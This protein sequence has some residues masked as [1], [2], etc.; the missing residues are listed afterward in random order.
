M[1]LAS[2]LSACLMSQGSG[3]HQLMLAVDTCVIRR[4]MPSLPMCSYWM[5]PEV[6]QE[7][8]YDARADIWSLGITAIEL[9]DGEP[10]YA[11][12]HPMRA[13][14]MIPSREPP[15]LK[16]PAEWS[17][18]F[19]DFIA[20]CLKKDFTQRPSAKALLKHPF[21]AAAVARLD[22]NRGHSALIGEL[23]ERCMPII[24]QARHE[25]NEADTGEPDAGAAPGAAGGGGGDGEGDGAGWERRGGA[26]GGSATIR[27]ARRGTGGAGTIVAGTM[28]KDGKLL[29]RKSKGTLLAATA[30][31]GAAAGGGGAGADA[32]TVRFD[33][34][35]VRVASDGDEGNGGGGGGG[36]ATGTLVYQSGTM[37]MESSG[38][39]DETA[40]GAVP[41]FMAYYQNK[42][43]QQ[44]GRPAAA[45]VAA[46]AA[47]GATGTMRPAASAGGGTRGAA[48]TPAVAAPAKE[49][50]IYD[51]VRGGTF[52][53]LCSA[54]WTLPCRCVN[55][56][57][58]Q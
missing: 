49:P 47:G 31:R 25:D 9:A 14:F 17:A 33:S 53:I 29:H 41:A 26:G 48:A 56:H 52:A 32:G 12:I 19:N 54:S 2:L 13:I 30:R 23:V 57:G 36:G 27:T 50:D 16:R 37:A 6:I 46:A 18:A 1:L 35:T 40:D 39:D 24:E 5:S 10:P 51:S 55:V 7:S 38:E 21:V 15:K 11:D 3:V 20:C 28:V 22:A 4:L 8:A 43:Q 42:Q 45:A 34:G 44:P 58:V